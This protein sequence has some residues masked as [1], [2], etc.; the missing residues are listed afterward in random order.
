MSVSNIKGVVLSLFEENL[1][2]GRALLVRSLMKSQTAS[3]AFTNV[4]AA[5]VAVVNTKMPEI[6]ELLLKRII[7]QFRRAFKRSDKAMCSSL[8]RFIA[9]LVNQQV[10]HE[11]LAL[12]LLTVLLEEP[13]DQSV[14]VACAFTTEVGATLSE[15]SPQGLHAIFERLRAILHEGII[16][17]RVQY[18]IEAVFNKRKNAFAEFPGVVPGLDLVEPDDQ[19]THELGLD[20]EFD[21]E[22]RLDYFKPDPDFEA[23]EAKYAVLRKEILGEDSDD[24]DDEDGEEGDTETSDDE[25]ATAADPSAPQTAGNAA[26]ILDR[27]EQDMVNLR[28]TIYLTIMSSA[29][30][31]ECAHKLC[32]LKLR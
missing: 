8:A 13:T 2:R 29:I 10:A 7:S 5:V 26:P 24:E 31:D 18:T 30:V 4:Y 19:I 6:G 14:E 16:D 20:E 27:T 1:V 15:L 17:K 9:H 3:P 21:L 28:R 11:I 32:K 25:D 23:S 22:E 12:Q